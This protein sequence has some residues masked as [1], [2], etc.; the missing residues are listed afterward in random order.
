MNGIVVVL[1]S[2]Q[3]FYKV[4]VDRDLQE[5]T[6]DDGQPITT[7]NATV[8]QGKFFHL[9][10]HGCNLIEIEIQLL[11][12]VYLCV[13][14]TLNSDSLSIK[15]L[16]TALAERYGSPSVDIG[17]TE[18]VTSAHGQ[19]GVA[20]ALSRNK[21]GKWTVL[22]PQVLELKSRTVRRHRK[23]TCLDKGP[24]SL[25]KHFYLS[26]SCE[27]DFT[28]VKIAGTRI[29]VS[30]DQRK[31]TD[32]SAINNST[33]KPSATKIMMEQYQPS[34]DDINLMYRSVM[35]ILM[36]SVSGKP[37]ADMFVHTDEIRSSDYQL[38]PVESLKSRLYVKELDKTLRQFM[39]TTIHHLIKGLMH[40][41][42]DEEIQANIDRDNG[43]PSPTPSL[44]TM[45]PSFPTSLPPH[46]PH[47]PTTQKPRTTTRAPK[48]TTPGI[49]REDPDTEWELIPR[50]RSNSKDVKD[51]TA[52]ML[53]SK[54]VSVLSSYKFLGE[55]KIDYMQ[56]DEKLHAAPSILKRLIRTRRQAPENDSSE[57]ANTTPGDSESTTSGSTQANTTP[58]DSE[59]TTP[60]STQANTT[61]GGGE[62]TTPGST[63]ANTT[64]ESSEST[65]PGS[66]QANTTPGSSES[67][68]PGMYSSTIQSFTSE[69]PS[70]IQNTTEQTTSDKPTS[71]KP[72]IP[73]N[74]TDQS[75]SGSS[76]TELP[77]EVTSSTNN[78]SN[79]TESRSS[80]SKKEDD[81][82]K[83]DDTQ[84]SSEDVF[85]PIKNLAKGVACLVVNCGDKKKPTDIV[86][87][88]YTN[89]ENSSDD[90]LPK[91]V[92]NGTKRAYNELENKVKDS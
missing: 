47:K 3:V 78:D 20:W 64:P 23:Y 54:V 43:L 15:Y 26:T 83:K 86:G 53:F 63:Q 24:V 87:R 81:S 80:K 51:V 4:V 13:N 85:N 55:S 72:S 34:D 1:F 77:N 90:S 38:Q 25:G 88:M 59:S 46:P 52:E 58:G 11:E 74:T 62:S 32:W 22:G 16:D 68:T 19:L 14:S 6:I 29:C 89:Y 30:D 76:T 5:V 84:T 69:K 82:P 28:T 31:E 7:A 2:L 44:P 73:Q 65:T 70:I 56:N 36:K 45:P 79:W 42:I 92:V 91:R 33:C 50:P 39:L 8:L 57:E 41:W 40:E 71:D 66:T 48:G 61:P 12:T 21:R 17:S 35:N 49:E 27:Q 9:E 67:T 18:P 10:R 60:G 75:S 37:P